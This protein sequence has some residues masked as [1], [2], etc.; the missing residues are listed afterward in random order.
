MSAR[1]KS[2]LPPSSWAANPGYVV[3]FDPIPARVRVEL[4][5]ETVGESVDA[6]VMYELGHAPVYYL[7]QAD[8]RRELL[9]PTEHCTHCPYKGDA[10]YWSV[11]VG[12]ASVENAV[13]T[14]PQPYDEMAHLAGWLGF[15]WGRFHAWYEDGERV[16]A[17]REIAGRCNEHTH[18]AACYPKL[19]QEWHTQKNARLQP[20]EF[21]ADSG[22]AVWWRDPRG[23]VWR[24]SIRARVLRE[25]AR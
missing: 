20:Y 16:Q 1:T 10:S 11:R 21:C 7:P 8:V 3:T 6:R 19:A 22:T 2:E 9:E 17:P 12:A 15:Y 5:G 13:W 23:R 18:F 24:E 25:G 4:A 14:Y